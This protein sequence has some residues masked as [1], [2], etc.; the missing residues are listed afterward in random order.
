MW[1]L[2]SVRSSRGVLATGPKT[3]GS[4][5]MPRVR[6]RDHK[7]NLWVL[8][9]LISVGLANAGRVVAAGAFDGVYR[10]TEHTT[11]TN[12]SGD[13][14][15]ID[16]D[17]LVLRIE[18]DHFSR[19]WGNANISVDVAADGSFKAEVLVGGGRGTWH[20][21]H[22]P[23]KG[24]HQWWQPGRGYWYKLLRRPPVPE[25]VLIRS[26]RLGLS[27]APRWG[28]HVKHRH[29]SNGQPASVPHPLPRSTAAD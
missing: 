15:K 25:E 11:L 16:N 13:C 17:H 7:R 18:N 21:A 10:G 12:N 22:S 4:K 14:A 2:R 3:E 6:L 1:A 5:R 23:N 19:T 27:A 26:M 9:V 24:Q 8:L 28:G 20:A 29:V